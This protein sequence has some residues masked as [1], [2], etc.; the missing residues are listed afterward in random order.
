MWCL[1]IL[2]PEK[3]YQLSTLQLLL[4]NYFNILHYSNYFTC[5]KPSKNNA[6]SDKLLQNYL[7]NKHMSINVIVNKLGKW[8]SQ[9]S[10]G[11]HTLFS[12]EQ[13][14]WKKWWWIQGLD[15]YRAKRWV[16]DS[17][18]I[19]QTRRSTRGGQRRLVISV[20]HH[21]DYNPIPSSS[22]SMIIIIN[23]TII[24]DIHNS[25]S[26]SQASS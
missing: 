15:D 14:N 4:N 7:G 18:E 26:L 19:A 13:I 2:N 10:S 8:Y 22:F 5:S 21:H 11:S 16:E 17:K 23:I 20:N 24:L 1:N 6:L 3:V 12:R 9:I 25:P